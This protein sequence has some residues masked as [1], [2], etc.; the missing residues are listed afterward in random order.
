MRSAKANQEDGG[1]SGILRTRQE[2]TPPARSRS[3]HEPHPKAYPSDESR[4][5]LDQF[6][7]IQLIDV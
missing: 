3:R 1:G 5:R 4:S 2:K 7:L 6:N